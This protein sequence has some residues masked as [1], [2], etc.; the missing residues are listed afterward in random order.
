MGDLT[1]VT[2]IHAPRGRARARSRKHASAP[3][4]FCTHPT[5]GPHSRFRPRTL[6]EHPSEGVGRGGRSIF[7][8]RDPLTAITG[9]AYA[10]AGDYPVNFSDPTGLSKCGHPHGIFDTIGSLVDCA[11]SGNVGGAVSTVAQA[12]TGIVG[13]GISA[14]PV[15]IGMQAFSSVT[16]YSVG[17]CL[18][19][20]ATG[21]SATVTGSA[22][23]YA[24]P[25]G[26]SGLTVTYGGGTGYGWGADLTAG[27]AFSNAQTLNDLGGWFG[28]TGGSVGEGDV[29][30][31]SLSYGRNS[32]SDLITN[33]Y[34]GV[35]EDSGLN[36]APLLGIPD[37]PFSAGTGASYTWT[38]PSW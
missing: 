25:S 38:Y 13:A 11:S 10:Y 29:A 37:A 24:T 3:R 23:Y 35:G 33:G 16:G 17:G 27:P 36:F 26:Q 19:G 2:A 15:G 30:S 32:C 12:G 31:G 22:C 21:F 18:G 6:G 8:N 20:S 28:Y 5:A 34:V 4:R 14:S 1:A 9:Q 7:L